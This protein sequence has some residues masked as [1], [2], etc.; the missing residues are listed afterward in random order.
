MTVHCYPETSDPVPKDTN[1]NKKQYAAFFSE[2][3]FSLKSR[4]NCPQR[5]VFL[6]V[7][8]EIMLFF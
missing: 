4:I 1:K 8:R 6:L 2:M 3:T 5:D 7:E